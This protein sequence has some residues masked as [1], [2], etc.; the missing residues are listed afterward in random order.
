MASLSVVLPVYNAGPYLEDTLNSLIVQTR[1]ADQ[2]VVVNDGSTDRSL[3]ILEQYRR[4]EA[5]L[6]VVSQANAGV[7]AAR[8]RALALCEGDF[9]ALMDADDVC[10]PDRFSIQ[11]E[12]MRKHGLG[13]CGS[14]LRTFGRKDRTVRYPVG[15]A[16]LKWNYLFMGRTIPNPVAMMH[17]QAIGS[18]RYQ[19]GLSFAEDYGFFLD[20][21]FAQPSVQ[22]GNVPRVLLD[23]RLHS[24]QAS[25][26]L[27]ELNRGNILGLMQT[28]LPKTGIEATPE[29]LQAHFQV[30]QEREALSADRLRDYLPLMG[31]V[32]R[33][34]ERQ[35]DDRR[36]AAA[37]WAA[38]AKLHRGLDGYEEVVQAAGEH[39]PWYR[40]AAD[41][42][43]GRT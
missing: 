15:D 19:E 31:A 26:R 42:F 14:W 29:Q 22:F 3:E 40:R 27:K 23:Y 6:H 18:I 9:I 13:V 21:L 38:L 7:A 25:Q 1:P 43:R 24:Q 35:T 4:K 5:R 41:F 2:I 11:L 32:T 30:W 16:E 12:F 17:R 36:L 37:H 34:L 20:I 10:R 28:L 8:N 33:W 39:W